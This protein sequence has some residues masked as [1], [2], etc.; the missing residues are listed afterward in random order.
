M[1]LLVLG[2]GLMGPAAAYHAVADP[3]VLQVVLGDREQQ[4]LEAAL[5]K[6]VGTDV[7]RKLGVIRLDL[8]NQA[9]GESLCS[10]MLPVRY[11][12]SVTFTME[13]DRY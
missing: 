4:Q 3:D 11:S 10:K 13:E 12:H 8:R 6:F 1:K 7:G 5:K 9:T 2:S